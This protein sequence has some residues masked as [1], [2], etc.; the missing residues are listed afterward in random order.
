MRTISGASIAMMLLC[1]A[2]GSGGADDDGAGGA[3][4][5]SSGSFS[6]GTGGVTECVETPSAVAT[7]EE[8]ALGFSGADLL[9]TIGGI[10][11]GQLY[12]IT[13]S[14]MY[15]THE[16]AGTTTALTLAF[17]DA[18]AEVTFVEST[19]GGCPPEGEGPCIVCEPRMDI[20]I[21]LQVQTA[22]GALAET[23]DVK[24]TTATVESASFTVSVPAASVAGAYFDALT[25][26]TA[27]DEVKSLHVEAVYGGS[28]PGSHATV[29]GAWNGFLAA[30]V[31][32]PESA[33]G[34]FSAH[35]YFPPETAGDMQ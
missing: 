21:A 13:G 33:T 11:G 3:T 22:D 8:T 24:L 16:R 26:V 35:G 6:S 19:G 31:G 28:F 9:A 2:C 1:N 4:T 29:P 17:D 20:D 23:V 14:T 10:Q 12:W 5:G 15:A 30:E 27:G 32:P 18:A 34:A 7:D 25:P